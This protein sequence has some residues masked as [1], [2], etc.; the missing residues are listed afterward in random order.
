M[1]INSTNKWLLALA[2][3]IVAFANEPSPAQGKNFRPYETWV[4]KL[5]GLPDA[6]GILYDVNDSSIVLTNSMKLSDFESSG[7][8][9]ITIDQIDKIKIRRKGKLWRSA[10]IGLSVGAVVGGVAGAGSFGG[11][12]VAIGFGGLGAIVGTFIGLADKGISINGQKSNFKTNE[13]RLYRYSYKWGPV[14]R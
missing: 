10:L 14:A 5:H 13:D 6:H 12:Q 3:G 11:L 4:S 8:H 2:L 1:K 7:Y 9:S